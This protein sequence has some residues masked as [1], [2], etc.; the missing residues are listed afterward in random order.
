MTNNIMAESLLTKSEITRKS[1]ECFKDFQN[2]LCSKLILEM[3]RLQVV[4]SDRKR[5]RCQ[6]SILG[7]QTELV[8]INYFKNSKISKSSIMIPYV[9]KNC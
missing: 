6:S 8:E 3:E 2:K 9:I 1:K 5:Y 4:E 7:L